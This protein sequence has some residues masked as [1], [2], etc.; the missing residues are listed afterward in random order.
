MQIKTRLKI[1]AARFRL[2]WTRVVKLSRRLKSSC[3]IA[4]GFTQ[5]WN[6]LESK[7]RLHRFHLFNELK[8]YQA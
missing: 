1:K 3:L 5:E 6:S 8:S 2:P 7:I 4:E